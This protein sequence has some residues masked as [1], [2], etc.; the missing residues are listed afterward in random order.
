MRGPFL[1]VIIMTI[2]IGPT[3]LEADISWKGTLEK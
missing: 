1:L 3:E 2:I